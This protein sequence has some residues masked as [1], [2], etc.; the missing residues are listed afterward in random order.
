[1]ITGHSRAVYSVAFSPD[2]SNGGQ[3]HA[4]DDALRPLR[5]RSRVG[6]K[7][8]SRGIVAG[9]TVSTFILSDSG[10]LASGSD[11]GTTLAVGPHGQSN[12]KQ[13]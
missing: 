11:D 8:S 5:M 10:T 7:P 12:S 6:R 4:W 2:E 3:W 1:M 9:S 13:R